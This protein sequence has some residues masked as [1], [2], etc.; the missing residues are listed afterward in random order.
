LFWIVIAVIVFGYV[1]QRLIE[2]AFIA[3]FRMHIHVW[4]PFDSRFRLITARRNP[5]MVILFVS[6]LIGRPDLGLIAVAAWTLI[7]LVVHLVRLVQAL[8]ARPITSWL[9]P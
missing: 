9:A 7:C 4:R 1:A 3:L 5:N 6:L 8:L 2:G